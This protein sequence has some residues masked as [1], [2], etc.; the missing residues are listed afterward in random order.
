MNTKNLTTFS[1]EAEV[2]MGLCNIAMGI[3]K[4][5]TFLQLVKVSDCD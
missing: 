2:A 5:V 3:T 1:H 4:L